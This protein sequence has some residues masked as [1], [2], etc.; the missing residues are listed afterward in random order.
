MKT[1]VTRVHLDHGQLRL[2]RRKL[3]LEVLAGPD[4]GKRLVTAEASLTV[5]TAAQNA[6]VLRDPGVSR[7]HLRLEVTPDGL[8]VSDLDS[9]NGT[10]LGP[11][12]LKQALLGESPVE[13][14]LADTVLRIA[15]LGEEEEVPLDTGDRFGAVL[16]RS[17]GMRELF[18]KLRSASAQNVTVLLEGETG[19]GKE[20]LAREIHQHSPRRDA[21]FV[22]LDCGA[23]PA[24]L[25]ESELFGHARGAF[26]GAAA[27]RGGAFEEAH[28][29]TIFLDEI[30][31]LDL[32]MQPRLLRALESGQVKR[33]GESTHRRVD[34]RIVAATNRDLER[35]VNHATFRADLFYRLA[36]VRARIP[37]LR[38]RPEDIEP[39]A[40]HLLAEAARRFGLEGPPPLSP[41]ALQQL[42]T[43]R[44]AGNVRELRNF[45][46]RLVA[47]SPAGDTAPPPASPGP[48]SADDAA[49][50]P[51]KEA[52]AEWVARFDVQYL[53][54]LLD[55]CQ[56]NVAEASR[57]SGIDRVHLFRLIKKYGLR[58]G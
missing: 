57:R 37:P 43:H 26:T 4:R 17:P 53:T 5:G 35:A 45:C 33:L 15:T 50:L 29:G 47:L 32:A 11:V 24:S 1:S 31:E 21:P 42:V 52:K 7:H 27:E 49:D 2:Y 39:L 19:T 20:L 46:E 3:A 28:G 18:G 22:I 8:L 38:E 13:L 6:L 23:I 12:G 25:I 36:V 30:G 56:D 40:L 14:R 48:A 34:V 10:L 58:Q 55:R 51:F 41:A 9:T 44:W 16:G 54:R